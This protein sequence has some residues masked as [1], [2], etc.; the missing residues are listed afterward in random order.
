M[1][2]F[3]EMRGLLVVLAVAVGIFAL[4]PLGTAFEFGDD[5]GFE[6]IKPFMCL[7]GYKLYSQIWNDQPPVLTMVLLG[8]FR[9]WGPTIL[10]ARVVAAGFGLVLVGSFYELVRQRSGERM[11]VIATVLFLTAPSVL[12]LSVSVMLEGPAFALALVSALLLFQWGKQK[13]WAWLVGSG[14]AM[15]VALQIKL[16]AALVG[17]A[18]GV[19][20]L[21]M[22]GALEG[23]RTRRETSK[24]NIQSSGNPQAPNSNSP[25]RPRE[26]RSMKKRSRSPWPSPAGEGTSS[27]PGGRVT[28]RQVVIQ[29]GL[30]VAGFAVMFS[31]IGLTWG[32][33]AFASSWR[34]HTGSQVVAGMDLPQDH[35]FQP[36]LLREHIESIAAAVVCLGFA[37]WRKRLREIAFP[38]VLLVTVSLVHAVHRPWWNYYYLHLAIPMAWL[39]GWTLNGII[40]ALL[41]AR[42]KKAAKLRFGWTGAAL[43]V[44]AALMLAFS[45]RRLEG[46]VKTLRHK[47]TVDSNPIV[48]AMRARK[49][50]DVWA[51]SEDGMYAFQA[52]MRV[53]PDLAIVMPK[54]FWSGQ[55]SDAE[56]IA[57][58]K[59]YGLAYIV[60]PR[61][62]IS[63]EWAAMLTIGHREGGADS[64]SRLFSAGR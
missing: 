47:P 35:K 9:V 44:G 59:D 20:F 12:L 25:A 22:S 5:E 23:W 63:S 10:A 4:L 54:R 1:S 37:A 29:G 30:W 8:A 45:E 34:S 43:C 46:S 18:I 32:H 50:P 38:A 57:R 36:Q 61:N 3:K 14:S 64:K 55:I 19:E 62:R 2:W 60:L 53:P 40:G 7:K 51:Y 33:G 21:L 56:I 16:T 28:L 17:P 11:A 31:L 15:A 39:A 49:T 58:C 13:H 26:A 6:V 41:L 48:R 52:G 24:S 27:A 42:N